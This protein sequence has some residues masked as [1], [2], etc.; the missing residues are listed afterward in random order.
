LKSILLESDLLCRSSTPSRDEVEGF[1]YIEWKLVDW[2]SILNVTCPKDKLKANAGI[3]EL[4]ESHFGI[5]SFAGLRD[6]D[7]LNGLVWCSLLSQFIFVDE[8]RAPSF[9]CASI[10]ISIVHSYYGGYFSKSACREVH[11]A[12]ILDAEGT[13]LSKNWSTGQVTSGYICVLRPVKQQSSVVNGGGIKVEAIWVGII[14]HFDD[15]QDQQLQLF[16]TTLLTILYHESKTG[17]ERA[18]QGIMTSLAGNGHFK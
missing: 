9:T 18:S 6:T 11:L 12:T 8:Y 10:E 4:E 14:A 13:T 15:F 5:N 1:L 16:D 7:L 3:N 2:Y 17:Q